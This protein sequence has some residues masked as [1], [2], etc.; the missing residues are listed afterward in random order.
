MENQRTYKPFLLLTHDLVSQLVLTTQNQ[1]Q[2]L[3]LFLMLKTE[4]SE[5]LRKFLVVTLLNQKNKPVPSLK[6]YHAHGTCIPK[7]NVFHDAN[8]E[9]LLPVKRHGLVIIICN[10]FVVLTTLLMLGTGR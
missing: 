8:I 9:P 5:A 1:R 2:E 3:I 7:L 4:S 6:M 10:I